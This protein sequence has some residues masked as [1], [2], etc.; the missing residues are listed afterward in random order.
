VVAAAVA[1]MAEVVVVV[2][3]EVAVVAE[4]GAG[5]NQSRGTST[6]TVSKQ[7]DGRSIVV[8]VS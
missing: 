6:I 8:Y 2:M 4:D 7:R 3:A 1:V 5:R